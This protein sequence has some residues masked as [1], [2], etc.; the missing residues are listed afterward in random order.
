MCKQGGGVHVGRRGWGWEAEGQGRTWPARAFVR[1]FILSEKRCSDE[2]TLAMPASRTLPPTS[3]LP[4]SSAAARE[5]L[6]LVNRACPISPNP[7]T[8]CIVS[9]SPSRGVEDTAP[10]PRS[11]KPKTHQSAATPPALRRKLAPPALNGTI[12]PKGTHKKC[13]PF[14]PA[15]TQSL[16]P[17]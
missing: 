15:A 6:G 14:Q 10:P 12:G 8:G 7:S 2:E 4:A 5:N 17:S 11:S 3:S 13:L 1:N 9:S 16:R